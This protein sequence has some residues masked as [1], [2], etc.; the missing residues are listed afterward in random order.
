MTLKNRIICLVFILSYT[1]FGSF[2][3]FSQDNGQDFQAQRNVM[4]RSIIETQS[5]QEAS[6]LEAFSSVPRHLFLPEIVRDMAYHDITVPLGTGAVLPAPSTYV[7]ILASSDI[8]EDSKILIIGSAA[9]YFTG[10]VQ[11]ITENVYL[12]EEQLENVPNTASVFNELG[13]SDIVIRDLLDQ[14]AWREFAPYTHIFVHGSIDRIPWFLLN[15]LTDRQ[16][17]II[18]PL[19]A[20]S[21][22]QLIISFQRSGRRQSIQAVSQGFFP[23][24]TLP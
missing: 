4:M 3:L 22:F 24:I 11:T 14:T 5:V 1:P 15:L 6:I 17:R 10:L 7:E 16:G 13:Y 18:A 2:V 8:D 23:S 19:Q 9:G 12:F 21:G 20:G